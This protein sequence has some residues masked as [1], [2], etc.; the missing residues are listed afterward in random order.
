[1]R[2]LR[3]I[4]LAVDHTGCK[5]LETQAVNRQG[6]QKRLAQMDQFLAAF[7]GFLAAL[8][9]HGQAAGAIQA[10]TMGGGE[11]TAEM[12]DRL[13]AATLAFEQSRDRLVAARNQLGPVRGLPE[14]E[15][16][17]SG[18]IWTPGRA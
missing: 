18:L 12:K 2:E 10:V 4:D 8:A 17:I 3:G 15:S 6:A 1:V 7:D 5:P 13:A 14:A 16:G 11:V 9:R